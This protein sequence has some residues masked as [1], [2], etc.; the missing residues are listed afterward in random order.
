[1]VYGLQIGDD[2]ACGSYEMEG[3]TKF[4][5]TTQKTVVLCLRTCGYTSVQEKQIPMVQLNEWVRQPCYLQVYTQG[6][7]QASIRYDL[8]TSTI[9]VYL[10]QHVTTRGL[11]DRYFVKYCHCETTYQWLRD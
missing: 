8:G 4:N 1:M 11:F 3:C 7:T 10:Q 9:A 6:G 5:P 2:M